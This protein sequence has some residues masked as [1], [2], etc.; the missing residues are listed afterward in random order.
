MY[1]PNER[2]ADM[3]WHVFGMRDRDSEEEIPRNLGP[4]GNVSRFSF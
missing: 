1:V 4:F 3:C 2:I